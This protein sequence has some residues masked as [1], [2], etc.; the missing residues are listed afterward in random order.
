MNQ[1]FAIYLVPDFFNSIRRNQ[2]FACHGS[3]GSNRPF[4][5]IQ[6]RLRNGSSLPHYRDD[7]QRILLRAAQSG[8]RSCEPCATLR[9][10]DRMTG[11]PGTSF[12]ATRGNISTSPACAPLQESRL[13]DSQAGRYRLARSQPASATVISPVT[14]RDAGPAKNMTTSATSS[15]VEATC[16]GTVL[17]T[18]SRS[19][20]AASCP[21]FD[22]QGVS[23]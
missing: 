18:V 4:S 8:G 17:R 10:R 21:P 15:G 14:F 7:R 1:S 12:C 6:L 22:H 13:R 16:N 11:S 5:V 2:P 20:S 9:K 3:R 23:M 19:V